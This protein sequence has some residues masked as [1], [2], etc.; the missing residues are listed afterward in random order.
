MLVPKF[1]LLCIPSLKFQLT[2]SP[3]YPAVFVMLS[4]DEIH[5]RQLY[6]NGQSFLYGWIILPLISLKNVRKVMITAY[7]SLTG[8]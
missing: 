7:I 4:F 5:R 3:V 2:T 6:K 1:N 8:L